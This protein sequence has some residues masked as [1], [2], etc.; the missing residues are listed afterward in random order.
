MAFFGLTLLFPFILLDI[1][2][3]IYI[4]S[5]DI[6]I[7]HIWYFDL[8]LG[9]PGHSFRPHFIYII[10]ILL[11]LLS[12]RHHFSLHC[13]NLLVVFLAAVCLFFIIILLF[14]KYFCSLSIASVIFFLCFLFN[15]NLNLFHLTSSYIKAPSCA[16]HYHHN[17]FTTDIDFLLP[18]RPVIYNT[19]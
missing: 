17:C 13:Y 4:I 8:N 10:R 19:P 1:I 18:S 11:W 9:I 7:V 3:F 5:C 6:Y 14:F 12:G 15:S 2:T 16:Y